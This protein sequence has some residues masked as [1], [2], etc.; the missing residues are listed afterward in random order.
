MVA[1]V[2]NAA[3]LRRGCALPQGQSPKWIIVAKRQLRSG[4]YT[5]GAKPQLR[6]RICARRPSSSGPLDRTRGVGYPQ[7]MATVMRVTD[8]VTGR[9]LSE[10]SLT[11]VP[12]RSS[13]RARNAEKHFTNDPQ[14]TRYHTPYPPSVHR[15]PVD[16]SEAERLRQIAADL[17]ANRRNRIHKKAR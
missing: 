13:R 3:Q 9:V 11:V 12:V 10:R 14:G 2:R 17:E 5:P 1:P 15:S 6:A 7:S 16:V 8:R 4:R